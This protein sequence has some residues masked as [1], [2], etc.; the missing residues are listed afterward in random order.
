MK[1]DVGRDNIPLELLRTIKTE[2]K[3]KQTTYWWK[4]QDLHPRDED[5]LG[6]SGGQIPS[7]I[8][9]SL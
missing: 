7:L 4:A 5:A 9:D 3:R 1:I 2:L 6:H 8:I